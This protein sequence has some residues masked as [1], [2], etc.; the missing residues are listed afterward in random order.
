MERRREFTLGDLK[1]LSNLCHDCRGCF[2]ACQYAPP[3]EFAVNVPRS[4]AALRAETYVDYAWPRPLAILFRRNGTVLSL[5][6]ALGIA[7]V[8]LVAAYLGAP[9]GLTQRHSGT[10]AF[11]RVIPENVMIVVGLVTLAYSA[12]AMAIGVMRFWRETGESTI[13]ARSIVIALGDVLGLRNLGGGADDAGCNDRSEDFSLTR[14]RYHHALFYGFLLCIAS[15]VTAAIYDHFLDRVAPYAFLS[16]PVLL[17][18]VGGVAMMAGAAGLTWLKVVGDRDPTYGPTRGGEVALLVLLFAAAGT[19]LALLAFRET[20]AMGLLLAIH[21]GVIFSF[22]L[23]LP[24]S[25][26]VHG[27][28]RSAALL[29][30][31][32]ERRRESAATAAA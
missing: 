19:G 1:Y 21:L 11:Y 5:A 9:G 15:T 29:R 13:A 30:N 32:Q 26:F 22:F 12:L 14:R 23:M 17:G 28:Y 10:G 27:V 31:A 4:L 24:Y 3:H 6:I 18:T 7:V 20:R 25:R 8:L 2:Y 16:L